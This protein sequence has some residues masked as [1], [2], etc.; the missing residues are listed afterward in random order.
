M[1][2]RKYAGSSFIRIEDVQSGPREG[3]IVKVTEG[4]YG[5]PDLLFARGERLSLNATN[6]KTLIDAYGSSDQDWIGMNVELYAGTTRY[7]GQEKDS[8]LVRPIS[9]GKPEAERRPPPTVQDDDG[10]SEEIPY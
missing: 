8:V 6:V 9:P 10:M 3:T 7:Q 1:D 4:R 2:M 5:K